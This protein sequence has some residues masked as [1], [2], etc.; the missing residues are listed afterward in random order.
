LI[1]LD[2]L[3]TMAG[4]SGRPACLLLPGVGGAPGQYLPLAAELA[5]RFDLYSVRAAGLLECEAAEDS[6][7]QMTDSILGM[8]EL[9]GLRPYLVLGWSFGGLLGWELGQRLAGSGQLPRLVLV[10]SSPFPRS[11]S[12][13]DDADVLRRI[14]QHLGPAPEPV[15]QRLGTVVRGQLIAMASYRADGHYPGQVLALACDDEEFGDRSL[16]LARWRQLAPRLTTGWLSAGH[17]Q[18]LSADRVGELCRRLA[19]FLAAEDCL[20]LPTRDAR[21]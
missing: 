19:D 5:S 13:A 7:P 11:A 12:A 10:D 20:E 21:R 14:D 16:E 1:A 15:R 6:V 8:L 3:V 2:R 4:P 17:Y 18:A 9:A